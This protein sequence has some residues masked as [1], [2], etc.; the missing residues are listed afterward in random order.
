MGEQLMDDCI[1]EHTMKIVQR[2]VSE[3]A[4]C[5][6]LWTGPDRYFG[7][8]AEMDAGYHLLTVTRQ[9]DTKKEMD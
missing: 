8:D 1:L 7:R 2:G 4:S 3:H 6:C 9:G 5:S